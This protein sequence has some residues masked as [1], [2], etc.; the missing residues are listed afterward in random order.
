MLPDVNGQGRHYQ[1]DAASQIN[2]RSNITGMPPKGPS[3]YKAN[4][5]LQQH[6]DK[7]LN[8]PNVYQS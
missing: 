5:T 2:G 6:D 8:L 7:T 4:Q 3:R 1:D